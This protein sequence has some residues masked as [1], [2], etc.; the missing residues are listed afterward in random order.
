MGSSTPALSFG[1]QLSE[2]HRTGREGGQPGEA[3]KHHKALGWGKTAL[4]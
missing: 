3:L 1:P 4:A 2:K